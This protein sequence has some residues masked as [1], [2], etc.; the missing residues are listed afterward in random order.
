MINLI[1]NYFFKSKATNRSTLVISIR[2]LGQ[3]AKRLGFIQDDVK[4]ISDALV[5]AQSINED[6]V[7]W[8]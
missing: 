6:S 4:N 5:A 7:T 1:L 3:F 2:Q 8:C